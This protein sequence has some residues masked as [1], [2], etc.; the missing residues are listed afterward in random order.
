[1][2]IFLND[3]F[4]SIVE[5]HAK[6]THLLVRARK[7]ADIR[8]TFGSMTKVLHTPKSDYPWRASLT[9]NRV[10][11]IIM[12]RLG[13]IDY[14]NFKDSVPDKVR[15]VPASATSRPVRSEA[16]STA[17][18]AP[19]RPALP[20]PR[21]APRAVSSAD[22]ACWPRPFPLADCTWFSRVCAYLAP[23]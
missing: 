22:C 23:R 17:A 1:M 8:H 15:C 7:K 9:R 5:D 18:R 10:Q 16:G 11:G 21:R 13:Q 4:F 2:W 19:P 12:Q 20:E 14:S 6:P 3:G